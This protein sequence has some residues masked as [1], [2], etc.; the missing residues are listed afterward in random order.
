MT[1]TTDL[2][3]RRLPEMDEKGRPP[4]SL[5]HVVFRTN[6]LTTMV[7]WYT[8][9][10]SAHV[11]F[12]DGK[13]AFLTYD[14]EHHRIGLI[15]TQEFTAKPE[16]PSVGFYHAAFTFS[17]LGTLLAT[18]RRLRANEIQPW[19][20]LLHGPT[21]SFYYQDPDGNDLE[22][23]ID[24]FDTAEEATA[25]MEGPVYAKNPIGVTFDPEEM[26]RR[27]EAGEPLADLMRR[28]DDPA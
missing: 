8:V 27:Y 19:R 16:Q 21:V 26:I 9:A 14:D 3:P 22:F 5:A 13:L 25:W 7:E 17:D 6:Q 2:T 11:V 28:P 12:D 23:Q 1:M 20:C 15:G 24:V 10:L 4:E 18:Y